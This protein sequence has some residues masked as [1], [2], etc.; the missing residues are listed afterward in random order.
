[1]TFLFKKCTPGTFYPMNSTFTE[2]TSRLI[3]PKVEGL[4][5]CC[6]LRSRFFLIPS[7]SNTLLECLLLLKSELMAFSTRMSFD[8]HTQKEREGGRE[9]EEVNDVLSVMRQTGVHIIANE[10]YTPNLILHAVLPLW[11][12]LLPPSLRNFQFKCIQWNI[13]RLAVRLSPISL[14]SY[15]GAREI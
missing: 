1:M 10:H 13:S 6:G 9:R 15:A 4:F 2:D 3:K 7:Y 8:T 11:S 12:F 14:S 5:C